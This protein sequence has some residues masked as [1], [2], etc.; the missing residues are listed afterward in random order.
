MRE[1]SQFSVFFIPIAR[2]NRR[3]FEACGICGAALAV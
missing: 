1:Y 2:W 3:N